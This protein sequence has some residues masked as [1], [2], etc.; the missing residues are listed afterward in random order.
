MFHFDFS[1]LI[2]L[3]SKIYLAWFLKQRVLFSKWDRMDL[4]TLFMFFFLDFRRGSFNYISDKKA[5]KY[6]KQRTTF[7]KSSEV[8][9]LHEFDRQSDPTSVSQPDTDEIYLLIHR[10]FFKGLFGFVIFLPIF[11]IK[12][13]PEDSSRQGVFQGIPGCPEDVAVSSEPV[14]GFTVTRTRNPS[15]LNRN[16]QLEFLR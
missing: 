5:G 15:G 8:V 9:K 11:V 3:I 2:A 16:L 1:A 7:F 10:W 4:L 12:G 6:K 14:L 13:V